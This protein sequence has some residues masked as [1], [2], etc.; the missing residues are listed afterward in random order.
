MQVPARIG[1]VV[2][3]V[4]SGAPVTEGLFNVAALIWLVLWYLSSF[5][6]LFMNKYTLD[7]F[8]AEMF[9]FCK[10]EVDWVRPMIHWQYHCAKSLAQ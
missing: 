2:K 3:P 9:L 8:Q 4:H 10:F 7:A 1:S 5:L 6:T